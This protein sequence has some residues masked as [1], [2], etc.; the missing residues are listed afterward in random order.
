MN[1]KKYLAWFVNYMD[2]KDFR[3]NMH[4]NHFLINKICK[5]FEKL[6]IINIENL[7]FF[8][9]KNIKF[10]YQLYNNLKLPSNIEFYNP[11]NPRDFRNFMVG[12]EL[13]GI[14]FFGKSFRH[15]KARILIAR[16]KIKLIQI[17]H[18][19]NI[20][21]NL[22]SL[23]GFFWKG[24]LYKFNHNFAHNLTVLLSNVG[25]ISKIKIRF[26]TDSK[27]IKYRKNGKGL[28]KKIF[29]Y[30]NLYFAK[31]FILVNSISFD[32]IT[33]SRLK[34]EENQ[35]VLLDEIM[36][37]PQWTVFRKKLDEKKTQKHYRYLIKLLKH[38]SNIYNKKVV[39]CLHP[40]D[41]L[42][43]KRKI[44]PD[45]KVVKYQTQENVFKAFMVLFFES[46]AI[47]DAILLKKRI[48]TLFSDFMDKNQISHGEDYANEV[49]I[50]KIKIE[51]KITFN[52]DDFLLKLDKA[53][54]KYS[55][56]IKTYLA[57][58]GEN[59]GYEKIIK[60]IKERFFV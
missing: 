34:I 44:F 47:L 25:L 27:I 31:E 15:L 50:S 30:I 22:T 58:D 46:S 17:S 40:N 9:K 26:I 13:I 37:D 56:Y 54:E 14:D 51:D 8:P 5:R 53:K 33:E 20:Q 60:T 1:D 7:N 41:N 10:D 16:Q 12:K 38:L 55:N 49:G 42:E 21:S 36:N 39:V 2:E 45:F 43:L 24:L 59:I 57:P 4:I 23:K 32:K 52:R 28:F 19:G 11:I 48:I 3:K 18:F 6:Y 29:N 35:I